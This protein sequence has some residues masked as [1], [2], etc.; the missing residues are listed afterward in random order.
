MT[1]LSTKIKLTTAA[2]I[3]ALGASLSACSTDTGTGAL[4]GAGGEIG[5]AHV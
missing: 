4:V 1:T 5:R 3:L 2:A